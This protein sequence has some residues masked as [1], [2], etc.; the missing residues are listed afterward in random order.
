MARVWFRDRFVPYDGGVHLKCRVC[1]KSYWLPKSKAD[2]Y[3]TCGMECNERMRAEEKKKRERNCIVCGKAFIPRQAQIEAGV[4]HTCSAF[5]RDIKGKGRTHTQEA[6][7]RISR[8][9][10]KAM[11]DGRLVHR[12]GENHAGWKGGRAEAKKRYITS[13]KSASALRNYRIKNP[14]KCREFCLR[15]KGKIHGRLPAGVVL[16]LFQSQSGKCAACNKSL[17]LG[18]HV[19][20]IMPLALGGGHEK[21]NL[22]L[23][24]PPC[25]LKKSSKHPIDFMQSMGKLL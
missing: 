19:D 23:L 7:E 25:N 5:C 21:L 15:R 3:V 1:E 11:R 10:R 22:Q 13:G 20:H 17:K 18:Y 12:S 6:L 24:C 2:L 9:V 4:G 16:E 8:S 14:H